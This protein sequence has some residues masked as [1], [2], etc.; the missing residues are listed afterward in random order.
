MAN[1][2]TYKGILVLCEYTDKGIHRVAYELLNKGR[3]IADKL[4]QPLEALVV[5]PENVDVTELMERGADR[6]YHIKGE[7]FRVSEE[8]V[9]QRPGSPALW[10]RDLRQTAQIWWS[11]RQGSSFR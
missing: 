4:G 6:V 3:E 10:E 5:A 11:T 9:P 1:E 7:C 8:N 2:K